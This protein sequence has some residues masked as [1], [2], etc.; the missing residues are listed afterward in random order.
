[1]TK[2]LERVGIPTAHINAFT[3]IAQ[4]VGSPRTVF[5]GHFTNPTGDPSLTPEAEKAYRRKIVEKALEVLQT[6]VEKPTI[7]TVDE[8]KEG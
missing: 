8:S 2:E 4:D 5:G 1:M 3:S 6:P 7:F